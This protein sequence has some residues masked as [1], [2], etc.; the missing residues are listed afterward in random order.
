MIPHRKVLAFS[1][2][3]EIATSVGLLV[4]PVLV[5]RLLLGDELAGSGLI[6]ARAFGVALLSLSLAVW[7]SGPV[8]G[9]ACRAMALYNAGLAIYLT[10]LGVTAHVGG[11]LLWP[12]VLIH[13]IV[14]VVLARPLREEP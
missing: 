9:Q 11:P 2:A 5:V 6:V 13:A 10:W 7:P 12:A 4:A 1:A 14:A 8:T 3:V